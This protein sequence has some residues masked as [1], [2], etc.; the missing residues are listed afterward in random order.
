[1]SVYAEAPA[2]PAPQVAERGVAAAVVARASV[3]IVDTAGRTQIDEELMDELAEVAARIRPAETLL[4]ADAMTGQEAVNIARGFHE[5][6]PLTG[7][8]LTKVDGDARGGAAISMRA[9]SG[10]PIQY[11][12][13]GEGLDGLELFHPERL[14]S[15]ILGMGDVLT[16]IER[17]QGQFDEREAEQLQEKLLR[18]RFTLQDF[19]EQMQRIRRM[20]SLTSLLGMMPGLGRLTDQVEFGRD[21]RPHPPGGGDHPLD[22]AGR[23]AR[24]ARPERVAAAAHR[25]RQRHAGARCQPVAQAISANEEDDGPTRWRARW[26][27][28]VTALAPQRPAA[29]A[30]PARR[31]VAA[32]IV[33]QGVRIRW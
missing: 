9:V 12:G 18:N 25:Q 22:D 26:R 23:A 30:G 29:I 16:L 2:V 20:G 24:S 21:G 7:L 1:M 8:I 28:I 6:V 5:R 14:S 31:L 10:V 11:L 19:L 4:V 13:T 17:A 3:C 27:Q 15:R 33:D 32:Q